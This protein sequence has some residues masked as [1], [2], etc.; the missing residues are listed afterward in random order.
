MK[1]NAE[2]DFS[3]FF[4]N[5]GVGGEAAVSS[6]RTILTKQFAKLNCEIKNT[7]I[8]SVLAVLSVSQPLFLI[9]LGKRSPTDEMQNGEMQ[10]ICAD[11]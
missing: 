9:L 3:F 8:I 6:Q 11:S 10:N 7:T 1:L 5:L 4:F 2:T